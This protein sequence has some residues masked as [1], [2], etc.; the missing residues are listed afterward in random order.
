MIS[1]RKNRR[2]LSAC[3]D[4]LWTGGENLKVWAAQTPVEA[5]AGADY[6]VTTLRVGGDHSR[7]LDE[8]IALKHGVIGQETTGVGGFSMAVRTIPVLLD[9]CRMI[10]EYAPNA[11]IFNFTNPSGLVTQALRSAG[12]DRVIGICDAPSSTKF[13]MAA[14]LGTEED[15]LYVEFFGLNHLSWIRSVK[16]EG[17]RSFHSFWRM[18]IF[19]G[20][21]RNLPCLIRNCCVP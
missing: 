14:C 8:K 17:K 20:K 3:A 18:T 12:Y 6:V 5:L 19:L 13:R 16:K 9:Y 2:S 7:V 11:W 4:M 10:K 15:D 21:S 1:R